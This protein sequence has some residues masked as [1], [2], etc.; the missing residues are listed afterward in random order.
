MASCLLIKGFIPD[1]ALQSVLF[2]CSNAQMEVGFQTRRPNQ[3]SRIEHGR[4]KSWQTIVKKIR[5]AVSRVG[6]KR[7][8]AVKVMDRTPVAAKANKADSKVASKV[9]RVA[10]V[11][12][13]KV[14]R[15]TANF[16]GSDEV[17]SIGLTS[18]LL[19][20]DAEA[21]VEPALPYGD[22]INKTTSDLTESGES[23]SAPW[24]VG[25][26]D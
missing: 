8:R 9:G 19:S 21:G 25:L 12:V 10:K 24:F 3:L 18:H 22:S 20:D 14:V 4:K 6:V 16:K 17:S 23:D 1:A 15:A 26:L 13:K 11:A 2:E 7:P 5:V